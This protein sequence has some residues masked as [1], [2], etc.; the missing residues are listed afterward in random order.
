MLRQGQVEKGFD[1]LSRGRMYHSTFRAGWEHLL[2]D[3]EDA[4]IVPLSGNTLFRRWASSIPFC[5][6]HGPSTLPALCLSPAH[7][8]ESVAHRL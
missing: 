4:G 8:R 2:V 3:M 6:A 5:P 7:G 1:N